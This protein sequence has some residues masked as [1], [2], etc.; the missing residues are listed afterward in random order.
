[1][2]QY[3]CDVPGEK[4]A[5]GLER[6]ILRLH[7]FSRDYSVETILMVEVGEE[8]ITTHTLKIEVILQRRRIGI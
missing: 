5:L 3:F 1:M 7:L 4:T 2:Y 8:E 6:T